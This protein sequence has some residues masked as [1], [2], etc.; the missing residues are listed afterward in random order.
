V[1]NLVER[2]NSIKCFTDP[3]LDFYTS[4]IDEYNYN[5][6]IDLEY[7]D[8]HD[9]EMYYIL[10]N[11]V[12]NAIKKKLTLT[13]SVHNYKDEIGIQ[14]S[15]INKLLS[16][17]SST[18]FSIAHLANLL[19]FFQNPNAFRILS[20]IPSSKS[21]GKVFIKVA[22]IEQVQINN[23]IDL[24]EYISQPL[25]H[26]LEPTDWTNDWN[27]LLHEV[28][29]VSKDLESRFDWFQDRIAGKKIDL[30]FLERSSL[31]PGEIHEHGFKGILKYLLNVRH[32]SKPLNRVRAIFLGHGSSG[33]TSLIKAINGKEIYEGLESATPGIDISEWQL[34]KSNVKA[35]LWDFGGQIMAHSTHRFFLR[36]RCLYVLVIDA[37]SEIDST[38]QAEY[39]LEHIRAFGSEAKVMIVGNKY[40]ISHVNIDMATLTKKH[41]NILGFFPLSCLHYKNKMKA[42]FDDF[43]LKFVEELERVGTHQVLF[44]QNQFNVLEKIISESP[45][46]AFLTDK[47]YNNICKNHRISE[48]GIL[49]RR[50]LLDLLDKL[51]II[52]H[53]KELYYLDEYILNPRWL[54]YG[55]YRLIFSDLIRE[56]Q[57]VLN[58]DDIIEILNSNPIYDE[59][60]NSLAFPPLKCKFFIEAMGK[61]H[62]C[63]PI[64]KSKGYYVFP[65]RLPTNTPNHNFPTSNS[66][67]IKYVFK[68]LLPQLI[69]TEFIVAQ[70]NEILENMVWQNGLVMKSSIYNS[71]ALFFTDHYERTIFLSI[72][73]LDSNEYYHSLREKL[74]S[75][76]SIMPNLIYEEFIMLDNEALNNDFPNDNMPS[77]DNWAKYRQ[78]LEM[79]K[80]GQEIYTTENGHHYNL[81][82]V[83]KTMPL[84]KKSES[85]SITN[86]FHG[87]IKADAFMQGSISDSA[88]IINK[89]TIS[90]ITGDLNDELLKIKEEI[91]LRFPPS[92]NKETALAEIETV[93]STLYALNGPK[94]KD[95]IDAPQTLRSFSTALK[96]KS[97]KCLAFLNKMKKADEL[98][99]WLTDKVAQAADLFE[100]TLNT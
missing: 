11:I 2:T 95:S 18:C 8:E 71:K 56:K 88:I 29:T 36:A 68:N 3:A 51:G 65:T 74:Y 59:H 92:E 34:P 73:G 77:L 20:G 66:L 4:I 78:L 91:Q 47:E 99:P 44:T 79:H 26:T 45:N 62:L 38:T 90:Q 30:E 27:N 89:N 23:G 40:D 93:I 12:V 97:S 5:E 31:I 85:V 9:N 17:I 37:R 46:K 16:Q 32:A 72:H 19:E 81:T 83:L 53:F 94:L 58:E 52:I 70:H 98:I 21:W 28:K 67:N 7:S 61:F 63:Y 64:P 25:W 33:K 24:N 86:N 84:K 15:N 10:R 1:Y 80:I 54:T 14:L 76:I 60:N 87:N 43:I 48:T 49:N 22:N 50:W 6:Y 35:I 96:N 57:G 55:C 69:T 100:N 82:K 41:P 39:W 13:D 75:V 42:M